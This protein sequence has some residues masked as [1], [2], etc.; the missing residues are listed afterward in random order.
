[1][2]QERKI[3]IDFKKPEGHYYYFWTKLYL[4]MKCLKFRDFKLEHMLVASNR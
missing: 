3:E 4:P 1:M 2:K